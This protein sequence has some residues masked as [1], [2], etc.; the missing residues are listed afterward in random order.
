VTEPRLGLVRRASVGLA[1]PR[2]GELG[3]GMAW[4]PCNGEGE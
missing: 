3:F 4:L 1:M 2:C